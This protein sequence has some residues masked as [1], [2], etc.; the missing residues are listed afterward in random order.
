MCSSSPTAP[1]DAT[2]Q[3]A[4]RGRRL[5]G[6]APFNLGS[7]ARSRT[8]FRYAVEHDY[9]AAVQF[10]ADGQHDPPAV[11]TILAPLADGADLVIGSRFA[12]GG[13]P[14]YAVGRAR[15]LAMRGLEWVVHRLVGRRFSDTS[16]GF[17][18]FSRADARVLR[19]PLPGGVHGLRRGAR[20]REQRGVRRARGRRP[21]CAA[22]PAGHRRRG[23]GA[24]S[25]TTRACS[26][27]S[28][29]R[30]RGRRA[31]RAGPGRRRTG[32]P[33][34]GDGRSRCHM[35]TRAHITVLVL[36][37]ATLLF[38]LRLVRRRP[39]AGQVLG[40]LGVARCGAR[41]WPRRAGPARRDL[42][43]ARHQDARL[44][45]PADGDHVPARAVAALLVG[46]VA[47]RGPD[48]YP[49]RGGRAA[50]RGGRGGWATRQAAADPDAPRRPGSGRR[51]TRRRAA[52][53]PGGSRR[54]VGRASTIRLSATNGAPRR[55]AVRSIQIRPR[56]PPR[57]AAPSAPR[58]CIRLTDGTNV[59]HDAGSQP[60]RR[61]SVSRVSHE[62]C[63]RWSGWVI[64]IPPKARSALPRLLAF[65]VVSTSRPPG[66][67][68]DFIDSRKRAR[69]VDVL[70]HLAREHDARPGSMP[71]AA[72][73]SASHASAAYAS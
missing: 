19:G 22:G 29:R 16:S 5:G 59:A 63:T 6:R 55:P 36:S 44:H 31:G 15:R 71:S 68:S 69:R 52:A 49:R 3:V 1:T 25:T 33:A 10:D 14:T 47:A 41:A 60:W 61:S 11:A 70:D 2:A 28:S 45:V 23:A 50:A 40:A 72:T 66:A 39:A 38:I 42:R 48:P 27:C 21:T 65:G 20:A 51:S 67:T 73:A 43:P 53:E 57:A 7:V 62:N 30:T 34:P 13:R 64:S 56:A 46:A 32:V 37:I 12:E 18:A 17:R 24:S 58:S 4:R 35:T 9:R 26:W 8:G 54:P